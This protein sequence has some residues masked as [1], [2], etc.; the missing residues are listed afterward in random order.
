MS[1]RAGGRSSGWSW[2]QNCCSPENG[3]RAAEEGEKEVKHMRKGDSRPGRR[4]PVTPAPQPVRRP[5]P[6]LLE[7]NLIRHVTDQ[8]W[9]AKKKLLDAPWS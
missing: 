1:T 3:L 6:S 8:D 2:R 9:P 7:L 4:S 5:Q